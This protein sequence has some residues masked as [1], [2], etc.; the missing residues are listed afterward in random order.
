MNASIKSTP[1]KDQMN[2]YEAE[3]VKKTLIDCEWNQ[4]KAARQLHTSESN[5][6]YK[7]SQFNIQ[8][9]EQT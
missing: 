9:D 2:K 1:L 4:S 5:I 6:R 7:M 3:I 8:K